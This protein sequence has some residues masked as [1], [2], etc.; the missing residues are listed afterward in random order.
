MTSNFSINRFIIN[1]SWSYLA[2][3]LLVIF[4][5]PPT[6]SDN[7]MTQ[8]IWP[9]VSWDRGN[10][11]RRRVATEGNNTYFTPSYQRLYSNVTC[12]KVFRR[13]FS[14]ATP[15]ILSYLW[16]EFLVHCTYG[17]SFLPTKIWPLPK[18]SLLFQAVFVHSLRCFIYLV[19][20]LWN[21][22]NL[23]KCL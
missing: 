20:W 4:T 17:L 5:L 19:R 16:V 12:T 14:L 2:G 9:Y 13:H 11:V 22:I 8:K 18:R 3:W 23:K 1:N 6:I 10:C 7:Q 15:N 21:E